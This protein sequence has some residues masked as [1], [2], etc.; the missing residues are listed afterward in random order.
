MSLL[1]MYAKYLF[2]PFFFL[3]LFRSLPT[4]TYES[5][6]P[7]LWRCPW[8]FVYGQQGLCS[9]D[10]NST[11][12]SATRGITPSEGQGSSLLCLVKMWRM[13]RGDRQ[14]H[15]GW[16]RAGKCLAFAVA[17]AQAERG[18]CSAV[19]GLCLRNPVSSAKMLPERSRRQHGVLK[20][21]LRIWERYS[22][23][24]KS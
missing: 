5:D 20:T 22:K 14:R 10:A 8:A 1:H 12:N 4:G 18:T 16:R 17:N 7:E 19:G 23:S 6:W 21:M 2:I 9:P 15:W 13:T 24:S 3:G 11:C